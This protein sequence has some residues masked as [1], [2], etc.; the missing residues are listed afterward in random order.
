MPSHSKIRRIRRPCFNI[1][2]CAT[3]WTIALNR[4]IFK[5][6]GGFANITLDLNYCAMGTSWPRSH[7]TVRLL[8]CTVLHCNHSRK[9]KSYFLIWTSN[10]IIYFWVSHQTT[11]SS[12]WLKF[13]SV[14]FRAGHF[15]YKK[16]YFDIRY[17]ANSKETKFAK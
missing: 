16:Q 7:D 6:K 9:E 5:W 3:L 11:H 14:I 8:Y 17:L 2:E 12:G 1:D 15:H 4:P 10:K 13:F